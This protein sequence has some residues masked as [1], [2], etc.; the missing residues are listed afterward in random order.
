MTGYTAAAIATI[1]FPIY[2]LVMWWIVRQ[3]G[4]IFDIFWRKGKKEMTDNAIKIVI[5]SIAAAMTDAQDFDEIDAYMAAISHLYYLREAEK[6]APTAPTVEAAKETNTPILSDNSEDLSIGQKVY[7][8]DDTSPVTIV[9]LYGDYV[10]TRHGN[11]VWKSYI[12]SDI[13]PF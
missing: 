9:D 10:M 7:V 2:I 13:T 6:T 1:G 4:K 12:K 5:H 11:G 8:P 3:L